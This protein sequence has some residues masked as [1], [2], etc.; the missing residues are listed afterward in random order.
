MKT[1][2]I[3]ISIFLF[4]GFSGFFAFAQEPMKVP[5]DYKIVVKESFG[6]ERAL[7]L[8]EIY[9]SGQWLIAKKGHP[10]KTLKY[11]ANH[12][13]AVKNVCPITKAILKTDNFESFI[14]EFDVEQ[15]GRDYDCRDFS[16][17]FNYNDEDNYSF[18]HFASIAD[19]ATHGIFTFD[20]GKLTML[21]KEDLAQPVSWGVLQWHAVRIEAGVEDNKVRVFFD[22]KLLWELDNFGKISGCIGFGAPDGAAK[23]DNLKI[24]A[25]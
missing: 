8:F 3:T 15:C 16:V 24:W 23:I 17:I 7:K 25:K 13:I 6:H 4:S 9:P 18:I 14:I 2:L 11:I 10:G 22:N 20:S 19:E 1:F 5:S 12:K 21:T